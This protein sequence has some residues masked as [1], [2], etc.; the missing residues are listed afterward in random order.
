MSGL[1]VIAS[2]DARNVVAEVRTEFRPVEIVAESRKWFPG[3]AKKF[4][5][6]GR[7]KKHKAAPAVHYL[8][9]GDNFAGL[10]TVYDWCAGK[11]DPPALAIIKLL[12][13]EVG[14]IVLE[15]LMRGCKAKWWLET[16]RARECSLA[17]EARRE[18]LSLPL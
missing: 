8:L 3:L 16:V 6:D 9:G 5:P 17:Y 11:F 1:S 13:S 7:D 18:Q 4:V 14:W 10:R 12:H 2:D 15:Y